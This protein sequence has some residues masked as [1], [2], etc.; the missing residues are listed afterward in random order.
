MASNTTTSKSINI[1]HLEEQSDIIIYIV[2]LII[3]II[4]KIT[5]ICQ[6]RLHRRRWGNGKDIS[7]LVE[8][9]DLAEVFGN[10]DNSDIGI[11]FGEQFH[12][13]GTQ[14]VRMVNV[15]GESTGEDGRFG[16]FTSVEKSDRNKW[17]VW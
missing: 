8:A 6:V 13:S 2:G 12:Q 11:S 10:D 5:A 1:E 17:K 16:K 3:I 9:A 15:F 7:D 4:W 14:S